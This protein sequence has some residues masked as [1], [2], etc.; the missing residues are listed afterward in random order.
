MTAA[1]AEVA[2]AIATN[3]AARELA[4]G[5]EAAR[6]LFELLANVRGASPHPDDIAVTVYDAIRDEARAWSGRPSDI[7]PERIV[8][9]AEPVRDPLGPRPAPRSG[10]SDQRGRRPAAGRCRGRARPVARG[11]GCRDRARSMTPCRRRL[12]PCR[13]LRYEGAG[14]TPRDGAFLLRTPAGAPARRRLRR[15]SR[16]AEGARRVAA[17]GHGLGH[18][19]PRRDP[20]HPDWSA[21]RRAGPCERSEDRRMVTAGAQPVAARRCGGDLVGTHVVG[22]R[23]VGAS[24]QSLVLRDHA[25]GD[26]RAA[27]PRRRHA[28]TRPPARAGLP[29]R[30]GCGFVAINLLG[31]DCRGG[32]HRGVRPRCWRSP[33]TPPTVDVRHFS[34]Y[35]WNGARVLRLAGILALH[36]A[37]LWAATL[38]LIAARGVWR[39]PSRALATRLTLLTLWVVPTLVACRDRVDVPGG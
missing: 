35:P 19:D 39:L 5:P 30:R 1:L 31:R 4:A 12:R 10:Q 32:A 33:S 11:G 6:A 8:G 20:A 2:T 37:A 23:T 28:S 14:D 21:S 16:R 3:P 18:R 13:S 25:R 27:G 22:R 26:G 36:V 38:V 34:L 29:E 15:A 7:P 24:A 9:P 17:N